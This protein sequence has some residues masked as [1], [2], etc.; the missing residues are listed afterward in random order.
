M[1]ICQKRRD[2]KIAVATV[3]K[4]FTYEVCGSLSIFKKL[5]FVNNVNWK[6]KPEVSPPL[7]YFY[8]VF[9]SGLTIV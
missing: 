3:V 1:S 8:I 2:A 7:A 6:Q 4:A 5:R 9:T